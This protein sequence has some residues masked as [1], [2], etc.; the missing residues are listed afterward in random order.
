MRR[1]F[2][3]VFLHKAEPGANVGRNAPCKDKGWRVKHCIDLMP[4]HSC[5]ESVTI[6]HLSAS[7]CGQMYCILILQTSWEDESGRQISHTSMTNLQRDM[8]HES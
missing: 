3:K 6:G 2:W 7:C 8:L 5:L 1:L 4:Q